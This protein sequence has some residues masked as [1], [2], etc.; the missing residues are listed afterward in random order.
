[1]EVKGLAIDEVLDKVLFRTKQVL[2]LLN[3]FNTRNSSSCGSI[4]IYGHTATGKNYLLETMFEKLQVSFR[5]CV[6]AYNVCICFL[7]PPGMCHNEVYGKQ[8][9]LI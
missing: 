5:G 3:L 4:F 9:K 7:P 6:W 8:S 2:M 1:M